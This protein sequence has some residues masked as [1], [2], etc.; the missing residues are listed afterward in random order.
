[1]TEGGRRSA[2]GSQRSTR[3]PSAPATRRSYPPSPAAAPPPTRSSPCA[4]TRA[5][6]ARAGR[7]W[8]S[9]A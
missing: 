2:P 7:G 8:R 1:L 5:R 4:R 3:A 6:A 9:S